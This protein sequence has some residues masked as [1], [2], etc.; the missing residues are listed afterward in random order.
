MLLLPLDGADKQGIMAVLAP[1]SPS[2]IP[3]CPSFAGLLPLLLN[4][5][6]SPIFQHQIGELQTEKKQIWKVKIVTAPQ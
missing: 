6:S 3:N 1:H 5:S 4:I 2:I